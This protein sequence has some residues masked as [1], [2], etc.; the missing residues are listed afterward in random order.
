MPRVRK[1][2]RIRKSRSRSGT[3][4]SS[5]RRKVSQRLLFGRRTKTE[6]LALLPDWMPGSEA[7]KTKQQQNKAD[8]DK[9][10]AVI[11]SI[12]ELI[13]LQ[14]WIKRIVYAG[15]N[16]EDTITQDQA[17]EILKKVSSLSSNC[18]IT[19]RCLKN[20]YKMFL[21]YQKFR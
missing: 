13:Q 9:F 10:C 11:A 1:S 15:V 12:A 16:Y 19:I 7:Y 8:D 17:T 20:L 4:R 14:K 6:R 21:E 18:Y 2:S 3:R 5:S